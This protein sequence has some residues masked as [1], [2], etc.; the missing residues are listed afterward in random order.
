MGFTLVLG[1]LSRLVPSMETGRLGYV[2][3]LL[4]S[5]QTLLRNVL[6]A[7]YRLRIVDLSSLQNYFS[8]RI[9]S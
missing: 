4:E 2:V 8:D 1:L 7:P 3:S 6:Q 9:Q 5:L